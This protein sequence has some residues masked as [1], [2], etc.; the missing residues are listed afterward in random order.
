MAMPANSGEVTL[1]GIQDKSFYADRAKQPSTP[2]H[3]DTE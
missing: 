2:Q 1:G 3:T